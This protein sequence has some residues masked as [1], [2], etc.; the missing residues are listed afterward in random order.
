MIYTQL[1]L[2]GNLLY[3]EVA[4]Q[5]APSPSPAQ[6]AFHPNKPR[7]SS[8]ACLIS[9]LTTYIISMRPSGLDVCLAAHLMHLCASSQDQIIGSFHLPLFISRVLYS[10]CNWT[11]NL[12][13]PESPHLNDF[14][15]CL[16]VLAHRSNRFFSP[17]AFTEHTPTS[18]LASYILGFCQFPLPHQ[19][20]PILSTLSSCLLTAFF[21]PVLHL[22][23]A[24]QSPNCPPFFKLIRFSFFLKSISP[25][26]PF[27]IHP[28]KLPRFSFPRQML[29][30]VHIAKAPITSPVPERPEEN[31]E[32][33]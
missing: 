9:G 32:C 26:T 4:W 7:A 8:V 1:Q 5:P 18:C 28:S 33:N 23:A 30:L 24:S 15:S 11:C 12:D 22:S 27:I 29:S 3:S 14:L 25:T 2:P 13:S 19:S 31:R 10:S 21:A 16:C 6:A 20:R 17:V